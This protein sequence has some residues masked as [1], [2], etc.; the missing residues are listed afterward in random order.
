MSLGP[1]ISSSGLSKDKIIRTKHLAKRSRFHRIHGTRFQVQEDGSW[2]I[3]STAGLSV[4][5]IDPLQ[6]KIRC[7]I[8]LAS[9]FNA[10]LIRDD[11]PELKILKL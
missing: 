9:S 2:D 7:S 6:L 8:V 3:F 1:V 10:M 11:L 5:D 4:I